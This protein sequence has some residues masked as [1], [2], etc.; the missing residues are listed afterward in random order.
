[1]T[2]EKGEAGPQIVGIDHV[3]ITVPRGGE[4]EARR[5]YRGILGLAEIAK[6]PSLAD[7]GG[8]WLAA[9]DRQLHI[10]TE[11]GVDRRATKAHVAYRVGDL[12]AWRRRLAEHGV[13]VL[14][15][16]PIPGCRRCELRDPFGNRLELLEPDPQTVD[17]K[18]LD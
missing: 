13:E 11:D 18:D 16:V 1:M 17:S 14:E 2:R 10:G 9:G 5:F 7:R 8:L 15:S 4:E 6:P 3:Q 12:E